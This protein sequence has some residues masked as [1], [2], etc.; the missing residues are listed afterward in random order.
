MDLSHIYKNIYI[1]NY[2]NSLNMD[3]LIKNDIGAVLHIGIKPKKEHI[4]KKYDE[5][6]IE[7][8]FIYMEDT[9]NENISRSLYK[10]FKFMSK[11]H[12]KNILVHCK[13]GISRSPTVVA[14]YLLR[15]VHSHLECFESDE[16]LQEILDLLR[17][18]RPCIRPND[19][20]IQQ[21]KTHE[22]I[23]MSAK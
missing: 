16:M 1:G 13:K 15:L 21:L 19:N 6:K 20:F 17:K 12:D 7:H 18:Y 2:E 22:H 9:M 4:L 14:Y 11:H 8:K 3:S 5:R 10:S 23:L